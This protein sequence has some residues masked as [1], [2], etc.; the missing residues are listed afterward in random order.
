[1]SGEALTQPSAAQLEELV[2]KRCYGRVRELR[3]LVRGNRLI[4]QGCATSYYVK[5][6]AQQAVMEAGG[7]PILANEIE[8]Q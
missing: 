2:Q 6:L 7:L 1:M 8:V 3:L 5:Q 4:L